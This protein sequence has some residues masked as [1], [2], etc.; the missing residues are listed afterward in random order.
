MSGVYQTD[1]STSF[2]SSLLWKEWTLPDPLDSLQCSSGGW[3]V[4]DSRPG[5]PR[6][7][8]SPVP[9]GDLY[10]GRGFGH[11]LKSPIITSRSAFWPVFVPL[12]IA[13]STHYLVVC[14]KS[15]NLHFHFNTLQQC[16]NATMQLNVLS[17]LKVTVSTTT[18][19]TTRRFGNQMGDQITPGE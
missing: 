4:E 8:S 3:N 1:N 2:H 6:I 13:I 9:A 12:I 19:S 5:D 10:S 11:W 15:C 7:I 14:M 16:Y 17:V 18:R